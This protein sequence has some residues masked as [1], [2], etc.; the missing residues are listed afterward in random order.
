[1]ATPPAQ[2]QGRKTTLRITLGWVAVALNLLVSC[3]WGFWGAIENFHEGWHFGHLGLNLLMTVAYLGPMSIAVGL[4]LLG[5]RWPRAGA[6]VYLVL[7]GSF[8]YWFAFV[9]PGAGERHWTG[10]LIDLAVGGGCGA[11]GLLFWF[12]RPLPKRLAFHLTWGLPLL[13]AVL[14]GAEGA[15][16]V[17]TRH[18]DGGRG[19]RTV[20]GSGVRLTWA[21]EGPG[22][23]TKGVRYEEAKRI[24]RHLSE[25][26]SRLCEEPQDIWRLPTVEEVVGSLTRHGENAGGRWD[27]EARKA[28]YLRWPDKETP[29]WNPDSEIIYWWTATEADGERV[30]RVAYNGYVLAVPKKLGMGSLA[31]R[32]VKKPPTK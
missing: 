13:V 11:V 19:V 15:W 16:R 9:R 29:L 25:D 23:P 17:A 3:F 4:G 18:D 8:G 6:C 32:A 20:E 5:L 28:A 27:R 7:G 10:L 14:S 30:Y 31:F 26:G 22:W 12:G 21:G 24:C 2:I 1:M